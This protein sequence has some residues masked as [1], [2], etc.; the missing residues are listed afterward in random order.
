MNT[1]PF[2][3]SSDVEDNVVV[4][5]GVKAFRGGVCGSAGRGAG[6]FGSGRVAVVRGQFGDIVRLSVRHFQVAP[7][8]L[9]LG[10][11]HVSK[12][13]PNRGAR[14]EAESSAPSGAAVLGLL[15]SS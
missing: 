5:T 7:Y 6:G 8:A 12:A 11:S 1:F 14:G 13:V 9:G 15:H 3:V 2:A 4:G 10:Q